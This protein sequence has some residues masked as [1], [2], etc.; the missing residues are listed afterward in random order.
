MDGDRQMLTLTKVGTPAPEVNKI[1]LAVAPGTI[2]EVREVLNHK[3][4]KVH[5]TIAIECRGCLRVYCVKKRGGCM[6]A[7]H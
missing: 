1:G 6:D 2:P 7:S 5:L 4:R 3:P